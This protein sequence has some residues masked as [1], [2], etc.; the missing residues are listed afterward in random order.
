MQD[1][2]AVLGFSY[3]DLMA[4]LRHLSPAN[5]WT[6]LQAILDWYREVQAAGGYR[7]YYKEGKEGTLQG[8][9]TAGGLGLDQVTLAIIWEELD[10]A[11]EKASSL[12]TAG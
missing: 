3:H 12:A 5:S 1:G 8:G 2:G 6:R 4:R 11:L 9:G 7:A 10:A